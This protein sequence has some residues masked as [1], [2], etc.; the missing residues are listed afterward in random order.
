MRRD[1]EDYFEARKHIIDLEPMRD[2]TNSALRWETCA[3]DAVCC[4][5]TTSLTRESLFPVSETC[6]KTSFSFDCSISHPWCRRQNFT[7]Y[8]TVSRC[9]LNTV[10]SLLHLWCFFQRASC[11]LSSLQQFCVHVDDVEI[12]EKA[13]LQCRL[14]HSNRSWNAG[15]NSSLCLVL[16][17]FRMN[18]FSLV[19]FRDCTTSFVVFLKSSRFAMG[20]AWRSGS[21]LFIVIVLSLRDLWWWGAMY[22]MSTVQK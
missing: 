19:L 16:M 9:M 10:H 8:A 17:S 18:E 12:L 4:L 20:P 15:S 13:S 22:E 14:N 11:N 3:C 7:V 1:N 21:P 2:V 6:R 5:R